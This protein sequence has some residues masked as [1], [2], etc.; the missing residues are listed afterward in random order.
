MV[1]LA[2]PEAG[3]LTAGGIAERTA[4]PASYVAQV[5]GSLVRAGLVAN[6][7]GR[8]G[9]YRLARPPSEISLLAVV[10]AAEGDLR[11]K[12]CIL[13]GGPCGRDGIHCDVHDAF[14]RAQSA[15]SAALVGGSLADVAGTE[16]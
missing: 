10:E 6:R 13:R 11:L 12:T 4:I 16:R 5:M 7:R 2:R 1:V 3:Q 15:A 9:G 14:A 8:A